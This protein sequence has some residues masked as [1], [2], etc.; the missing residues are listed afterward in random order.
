MVGNANDGFITSE[1]RLSKRKLPRRARRVQTSVRDYDG[2]SRV[3]IL[4]KTHFSSPDGS[5]PVVVLLRLMARYQLMWWTTGQ[6]R[7]CLKK[8]MLPVQFQR[9]F[10]VALRRGQIER[11][12]NPDW[13]PSRLHNEGNP[14]WFYK[15][16]RAGLSLVALME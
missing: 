16:T 4:K 11:A 7:K 1:L 14:T 12:K 15:I 9:A 10:Q 3:V 13:D 8:V 5:K 6:I 2:P